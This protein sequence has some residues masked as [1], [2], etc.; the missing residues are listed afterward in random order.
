MFLSSDDTH[1][2]HGIMDIKAVFHWAEFV[3]ENSLNTVSMN[4]IKVIEM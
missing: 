4:V 3:V 1:T 2:K